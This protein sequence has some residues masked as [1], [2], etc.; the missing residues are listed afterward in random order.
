MLA[1]AP[2]D[3][4]ARLD[5]ALALLHLDRYRDAHAHTLAACERAAGD[6]SLALPRIE[7]L[8]VFAEHG[9]M[10]DIGEA[11]TALHRIAPHALALGASALD[12]AGATRAARAWIAS[13]VQSDP[14]DLRIR[15]NRA[16]LAINAGEF[17]AATD[18]LEPVAADTQLVSTAHWLLAMANVQTPARNHVPRLRSLLSRTDLAPHDRAPLAFALHKELD[19]LGEYDAAW[20]AL[21][22]GCRAKRS[23]LLHDPDADDALLDALL[24]RFREMAPAR[25]SDGPVPIFI[26]GVHRSGTSLLERI[27]EGHPQVAA[28]GESQRFTAQLREATDHHVVGTIDRVLVDRAD[29][30]DQS[31]LARRYLDAH[32]DLAAGCSHFTEKQ[33]ANAWLLGF[34]QRALPQARVLHLVR[35]PMATCWSNLRELFAGDNVACSYDQIELARHCARHR[36]LMRHWHQTLPGFVLDVPYEGLVRDSSGWARRVFEFCGL[37]WAPDAVHVE[38][39]TGAVRTASAAQVRQPIHSRS[40]QRWMPYAEHLAPLQRALVQLRV[41]D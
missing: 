13:A 3:D 8:R 37:P 6:P 16:M 35:D 7:A 32:A 25:R 19:D 21:D 40:V 10:R 24:V 36:R 34:L 33:P 23:T 28:G 29:A 4:H 15:V 41:L 22:D 18:D 31:A 5:L 26:V 30:I 39:R 11:V 9:R 17:A 14:R 2:D 1:Q 20:H 27:L 38:Q 12:A